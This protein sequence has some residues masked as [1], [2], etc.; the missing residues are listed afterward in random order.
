MIINKGI[1]LLTSLIILVNSATLRPNKPLFKFGIISD[2]Q[3]ANAEDAMNFQNTRLRRYKQSLSIFQDAVTSW[4][5]LPVSEVACAICLGDQLDGKTAMSKSQSACLSDLKDVAKIAN[6][7]IH[8]A[9]GNHD[10]YAFDRKELYEHFTPPDTALG[11]SLGGSCSPQKLYYDWTPFPGWRFVMLDS[12]DVSM[13]GFSTPEHLDLA[14]KILK[15]NNP[16][17]LT[18]SGGWFKDLPRENY[19]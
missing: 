12:Y 5:G 6:M 4:N 9:M 16:N 7:Q 14:K 1:Y 18:Q 3:Y 2:I 10:Y 15:E 17:D 13:I 8:Y 19:R 11:D